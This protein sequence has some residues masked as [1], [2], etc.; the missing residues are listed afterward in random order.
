MLFYNVYVYVGGK[1]LAVNS[2]PATY[3]VFST[4]RGHWLRV[5]KCLGG[6][7]TSAVVKLTAAAVLDPE[8]QE[9][10]L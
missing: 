5:L 6:A 9:M 7:G 8:I 4:T 2:I 3:A 10:C 1:A